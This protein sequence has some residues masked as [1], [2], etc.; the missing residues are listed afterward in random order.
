[1]L[2]L[3]NTKLLLVNFVIIFTVLNILVHSTYALRRKPKVL[4]LVPDEE[5][6]VSDP[7]IS[8]DDKNQS[9]SQSASAYTGNLLRKLKLQGVAIQFNVKNRYCIINNKVY[10]EKDYVN[11]YRVLR[12][13]HDTVTLIDSTNKEKVLSF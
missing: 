3:K 11:E 8:P 9:T 1:M 5:D 10:K 7:T 4:E 6:I 12:I 13:E 2:K